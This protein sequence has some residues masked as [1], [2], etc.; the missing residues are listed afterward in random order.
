MKCVAPLRD[1]DRDDVPVAGG[2]GANLGELVRA[3]L[4]VPGGFVITTAGYA[5]GAMSPS[6]LSHPRSLR[7]VRAGS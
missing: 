1:F 5:T 2:K 4:L 3:G 6:R 7:C